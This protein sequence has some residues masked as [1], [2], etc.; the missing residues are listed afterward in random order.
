MVASYLVDDEQFMRRTL[1]LARLGT[2]LTSPNPMVGALVV[3]A[4]VII[5]EGC[6]RYQEKKHAEV[7]ALEKAAGRARGGTLYLNLEPCC[8]YGRTPPCTDQILQ[9]GIQRVVVAMTDP[10]PLVAG[11][12]IQILRESGI[13]VQTG[14]MEN[15]ARKLNEAFCKYI[16]HKIPFVT[17]KAGMTLDGKIAPPHGEERHITGDMSWQKVHQLRHA[18]DAILVG[19]QT[20]LSDDPLLTDRSESL[21]HRPL[22]RVVLDRCLR[23]PPKC[24]LAQTTPGAVTMIFC[25]EE[26]HPEKKT[27]LEALGIEIIVHPSQTGAIPLSFVLGEL[28]RRQIT[29][30]LVEGGGRTH[31]EF[32]KS[33]CVDKVIFFVAP[34]ILG[35]RNALSVVAGEGFE[36]LATAVPL[37]FEN[38]ER[39]GPDVMIES[40]VTP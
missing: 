33:G 20:V 38:I 5:G 30:L 40:Y 17:L 32:L 11:K 3:Q 29:S 34:R 23:T 4:G 6:H 9:S 28:G 19:V 12:G 39:L 13:E 15:E 7:L 26:H 27:E 21:R 24:R 18:A 14:L 1:E 37:H 36:S 10:N 22:W 35:G 31:F 25:G 2:S 8:H 16:V